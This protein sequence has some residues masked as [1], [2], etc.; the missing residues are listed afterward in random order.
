MSRG[1]VSARQRLIDSA[2]GEQRIAVTVYEWEG[3]GSGSSSLGHMSVTVGETSYSLS[4]SGM[5]IRTAAEYLARND[6][7]GARAMSLNLT[8]S[9][10]NHLEASLRAFDG[11]RYNY[12]TVNCA[13]LVQEALS[14]IGL[15]IPWRPLPSQV[16]G[17]VR[18]HPSTSGTV[19]TR[20]N[21]GGSLPMLP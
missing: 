14:Q 1:G 9:Q 7:R 20:R 17:H 11:S 6:F 3:A 8:S 13:T 19:D 2:Y 4:P 5:D 15:N 18:S 12:L 21:T 10:A 16:G